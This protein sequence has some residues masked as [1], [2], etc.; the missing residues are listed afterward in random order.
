MVK[1]TKLSP[2][3][4]QR[5]PRTTSSRGAGR[6]GPEGASARRHGGWRPLPHSPRS[7]PVSTGGPEARGAAM[8]RLLSAAVYAVESLKKVFG[9]AARGGLTGAA[10]GGGRA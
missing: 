4:Q 1:V 8:S 3:K 2:Q 9:A 7:T 10:G 6:K 5:Y